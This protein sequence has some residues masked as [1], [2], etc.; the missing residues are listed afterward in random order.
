MATVCHSNGQASRGRGF[1]SNKPLLHLNRW[2]FCLFQLHVRAPN[3]NPQPGSSGGTLFPAGPTIS[4]KHKL[5]N[6]YQGGDS[7]GPVVAA[8]A[9]PAASQTPTVEHFQSQPAA[10]C[11]AL[12]D[13]NPTEMNLEDTESFLSFRKVWIANWDLTYCL[14]FGGEKKNILQTSLWGE[15]PSYRDGNQPILCI[16]IWRVYLSR[17]INKKRFDIDILIQRRVNIHLWDEQLR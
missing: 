6:R 8:R 16:Q 1:M 4:P 17:I 14:P 13:F 2:N 3:R 10:L 15:T 12:F 11:K 9:T 7:D 5:E